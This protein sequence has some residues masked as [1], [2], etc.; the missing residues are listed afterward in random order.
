MLLQSHEGYIHV[1]PALPEE[2]KNGERAYDLLNILLAKCTMPNLWDSHPPFQIDG[3]FGGTAGI[4]EMLLQS[5]EGY[6]HVLPALPKVWENGSFAGLSARGGFT[7]SAKWK[8]GEIFELSVFAKRAGKVK[9]LLGKSGEFT[10][11]EL[12]AGETYTW[13]F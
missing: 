5:H 12:E 6:I 9:I 10:E 8:K 4:A 3:N 1:L 13:S 11:R 2:W 7:V